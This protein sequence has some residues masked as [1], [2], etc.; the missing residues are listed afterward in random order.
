MNKVVDKRAAIL[1]AALKL[2]TEQGFHGSPTSRI[3]K[4][5]GIGTGTLFHYFKTKEELINRLY[6]AIKAELISD[7]AAGLE[8]ERTIRGKI[9]RLWLNSLRWGM[10]N[11]D[12]SRFFSQFSASPYISTLTREEATEHLRF[13]HDLIDE[14]KRQ[15]VLKDM[16]TDLIFDFTCGVVQGTTQHFFEYPDKFRDENYLEMAFTMFWDSIRR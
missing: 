16:P 2:F 12:K 13:M 9:R 7:L 10:N 4:E 8:E 5:A 6:L 14:G 3:A 11:P 15:D 1:D